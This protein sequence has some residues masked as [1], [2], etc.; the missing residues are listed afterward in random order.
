MFST[1]T[2]VIAEVTQDGA[3]FVDDEYPEIAVVEARCSL[4]SADVTSKSLC[5]ENGL[6][7]SKIECIDAAHSTCSS[8][9]L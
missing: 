4:C 3:S 5:S 7:E 8:A 1:V 9:I 2:Q 6:I